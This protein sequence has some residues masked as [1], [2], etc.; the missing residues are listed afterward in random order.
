M[1][2]GMWVVCDRFYDSTLAY[3][4]YGQGADLHQIAAQTRLLGLAP[5]LTLVLN[6]SASVAAARLAGRGHAPDR[7]ERRD[8]DFHARVNAGFLQV[9]AS[10]PGRCVVVEADADLQIVHARVIEV[11][12]ARLLR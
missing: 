10:D 9:A 11:V 6:V 7:Y 2:G 12:A 4:G 1:S 8:V 5:D 3:Q